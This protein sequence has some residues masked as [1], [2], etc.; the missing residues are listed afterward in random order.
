MNLRITRLPPMTLCSSIFAMEGRSW[1]GTCDRILRGLHP[2]KLSSNIGNIQ[3]SANEER[4][5]TVYKQ[6]VHGFPSG[7]ALRIGHQKKLEGKISPYTC[8]EEESLGGRGVGLRGGI[9][10]SSL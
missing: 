3:F 6:S 5:G 1:L 2:W 4:V 8:L 7:G 9:T 10:G